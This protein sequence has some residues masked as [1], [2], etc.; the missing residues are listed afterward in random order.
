MA[1]K[2]IIIA[3]DDASCLY[4]LNEFISKHG[5]AVET[6]SDGLEALKLYKANPAQIVITDIEMPVMDGNELIENLIS[7]EIPPVIFVTTGNMNSEMIIDIMK[8]GVFDYIIKPVNLSDLSL[9]LSRAF[10]A[11]EL[12]LAYEI[13][14]REKVIRLENS[15][16]WYRFEEKLNN[17]NK[18]EIGDNLFNSL[19]TSFNQGAGFGSLVTLIGIITSTAEKIGDDYK[20]DGEL[21]NVVKNNV[22]LAEK[23]LQTFS[24]ISKISTMPFNMEKI[25]ISDLYNIIS[26]EILNLDSQIILRNHRIILSDKKNNFDEMYVQIEKEY[27]VKAFYEIIMNS[28]KFSPAGSNIIIIFQTNNKAFTLSIFNDIPF[29]N[30]EI[31]GIP[32]GYENLVFE[33]F[34][35]LSKLVVEEYGTLDYGLGLTLAE[36]IISKHNARIAIHNI[37]DQSDISSGPKLKVECSITFKF[38]N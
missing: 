38:T 21:F 37:T 15:L 33:P 36:K 6:A 9:K 22:A 17:R 7:L 25:S 5:Y 28:L 16:E 4:L 20:I 14:Q 3:E 19:L 26:S 35:R 11:Y 2:R 12:K 24:E 34:Y 18:R 10:E 32:M 29:D 1:E 13:S 23:A 27:F 31:K 8:K 30:K